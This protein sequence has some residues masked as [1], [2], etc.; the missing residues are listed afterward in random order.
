MW[1]DALG[2]LWRSLPRGW[3]RLGL[4]MMM[5]RFTVTAGAVIEDE[6]G[7]IL[8]LRH[9]YRPGSGWGIPGGFIKS[10]EQPEA[11]LRRELREEIDVEL[12]NVELAFV[13]TLRRYRQ[14]E[15]IFRARL[16]GVPRPL[17]SEVIEAQWFAR[18]ELPSGLSTDQREL[19]A[20]ALSWEKSGWGN[21]GEV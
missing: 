19:L 4:V 1:R 16:G 17:S 8:L 7:R 3:R 9:R 20:R 13:R 2:M 15:T 11:A 21:E 6:G 5:P 12:K 10:G 18:T 14:V